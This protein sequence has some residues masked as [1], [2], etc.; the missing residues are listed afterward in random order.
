MTILKFKSGKSIIKR[1]RRCAHRRDPDH[2]P[3]SAQHGQLRPG[4]V[5]P[6]GSATRVA[7]RSPER[8]LAGMAIRGL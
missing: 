3:A 7:P 1:R 8:R 5:R 6:T 4:G 2:P